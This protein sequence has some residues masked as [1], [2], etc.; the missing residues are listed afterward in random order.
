ML[1]FAEMFLML[2]F[3]CKSRG[4][5]RTSLIQWYDWYY[6][7]RTRS[8]QLLKLDLFAKRSR[9]YTPT[10]NTVY[11]SLGCCPVSCHPIRRIHTRDSNHREISP[12]SHSGVA[13]MRLLLCII[14]VSC[15]S[16]TFCIRKG[17]PPKVNRDVKNNYRVAEGSTVVTL[18]CPILTKPDNDGVIVT[19]LKDGEEL[20]NEYKITSNNRKLVIKSPH[21]S[22][23]GVFTCRA[24]NG[25][26]YAE[27]DFSLEVFDPINDIPL[28]PEESI[29]IST[30]PSAPLWYE[31]YGSKFHPSS[32][33]IYFNTGDRLVL[34]CPA[35]GNPVPEITW[36]KN[37]HVLDMGE[38]RRQRS[39]KL[40]LDNLTR[41]D[42]G[43]YS[44][45]LE[46][47][48]GSI[49]NTFTVIVGGP[50]AAMNSLKSSFE[51]ASELDSEAWGGNTK[52]APVIDDPQNATV[53][54][55]NTAKF[56]C[57]LIQSSVKLTFRWL[58]Q[59]A[60]STEPT[61]VIRNKTFV[62]LDQPENSTTVT[63]STK[64]VR[65]YKNT[66]VIDSAE[67]S[68]SGKYFCVITSPDG[69]VGYRAAQLNVVERESNVAIDPVLPLAMI[70]IGGASVVLVVIAIVWLR[71]HS[72]SSSFNTKSS[73]SSDCYP[74]SNG[75]SA[76]TKTTV[77]PPMPPPP[78]PRIPLPEAPTAFSP[79]KLQPHPNYLMPYNIHGST[80]TGSPLLYTG[81]RRGVRMP[82]SATL[83]RRYRP[84][85]PMPRPFAD[86]EMS[87]LSSNIYDSGSPLPPPPS[88]AGVPSSRSSHIYCST[89]PKMLRRPRGDHVDFHGYDDTYLGGYV[90][91]QQPF[92]NTSQR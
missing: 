44:C 19:W 1:H 55:G 92:V 86:D 63:T 91:E 31:G 88:H 85:P 22:D 68:D 46:N 58:K 89:S 75:T 32:D 73:C 49:E 48:H 70:I 62:I 71:C 9:T 29:T 30:K 14:L 57:H 24:V 12:T 39:A 56:T 27:V 52:N 10:G 26:G 74:I 59:T 23:T 36:F 84:Q 25:F 81:D 79:N 78:P 41:N 35:V 13:R 5:A 37:G 3:L 80:P 65:V 8:W 90:Y 17:E 45:R 15:I 60:G 4:K 87:R 53:F 67:E 11:L 50:A 2:F 43:S 82:M 72:S 6:P 47:R 42:S 83:D 64:G 51:Q 38:L 18:E 77:A 69:Y 16:P 66:L 54:R 33:P 7:S 61:I 28:H 76:L 21:R 20:A 34:R 40:Q